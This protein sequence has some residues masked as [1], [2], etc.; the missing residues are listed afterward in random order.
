MMMAKVAEVQ[1]MPARRG[2]RG[3]RVGPHPVDV[4]VGSRVRMRRTLL[5][6]SQ[7]KLGNAL[8]LTFQQVQK[9]ESRTNRI[10]ASRL[11]DLS[12]VL[13]VATFYFISRC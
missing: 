3:S 13:G 5:G 11:Y 9:Y 1:V 12:C 2:R 4:H 7:E 8:A 10:G 6:M